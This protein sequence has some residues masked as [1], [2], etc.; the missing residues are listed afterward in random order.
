MRNE[1]QGLKGGSKQFW[2]RLHRK[3]VEDFY[4]LHGPEDTM[5]EFNMKQATLVRFFERKGRDDRFNRLSESDRWVLRVA[6]QGLADLTR[7]IN[8]LEGWR[9][10]VSPVLAVGQALIDSTMV[11]IKAKVENKPLPADPLKL[12]NFV[13]S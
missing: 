10:E 8:E 3:E 6:K 5:A 11:R 7:R 13:K 1:L 2:L 12:D 9:E 4:F